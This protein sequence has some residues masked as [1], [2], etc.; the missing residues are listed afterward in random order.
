MSTRGTKIT[1]TTVMIPSVYGVDA[2]F[3]VVRLNAGSVEDGM[4]SGNRARNRLATASPIVSADAAKAT[5]S[6]RIHEAPSAAS[7]ATAARTATTV[8]STS[9][10]MAFAHSR[11]ATATTAVTRP[12]GTVSRRA[13]SRISPSVRRVR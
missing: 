13:R 7:Q 2:A 12:T 6:R 9:P 3:V 4:T 1:A 10:R 8:D 11:N 5:A